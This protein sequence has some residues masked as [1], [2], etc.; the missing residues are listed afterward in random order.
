[1]PS[2]VGSE[3][4][5]RDRCKVLVYDDICNCKNK[6]VAFHFPYTSKTSNDPCFQYFENIGC[7][8]M[9]CDH[10][11]GAQ[12]NA[13]LFNIYFAGFR[14]ELYDFEHHEDI[15]F[16][17]FNTWALRCVCNILKVEGDDIKL[18]AYLTQNFGIMYSCYLNPFDTLMFKI[19]FKYIN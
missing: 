9:K 4:C 5:I 12:Y 2:L 3:M 10:I 1:M 18:P 19:S 14:F 16:T 7:R 8:F 15:I 11:I 17:F 6:V 13:D